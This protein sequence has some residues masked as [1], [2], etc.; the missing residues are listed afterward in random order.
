M[1][2]PPKLL[3]AMLKVTIVGGVGVSSW[4]QTSLS[5]FCLQHLDQIAAFM[6]GRHEGSLH[7]R[8]NIYIYM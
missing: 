2:Y 6:F 8:K 1:V 3:V 7:V 5:L 4:L